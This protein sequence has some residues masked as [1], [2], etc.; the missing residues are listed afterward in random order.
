V[1]ISRNGSVATL[2]AYS[3]FPLG[4]A[5]A[6]VSRAV[7][8]VHG[9]SR[10][11]VDYY[12]YAARAV[13]SSVLVVAPQLQTSSDSPSSTELHWDDS[14]WKRGDQSL[15][16]A[17]QVSS[18][19]VIDDLVRAMRT[20][21]PNLGT[22]VIAGHS[23]GGQFVQ[24]YAATSTDARAH[25]VVANPSSYLYLGPERPV[26]GAFSIPADACSWYNHYRYGL[27]DLGETPYVSRI[28]AATL[29]ARYGQ[30][31]VTYLLG[32]LDTDPNASD[33]DTT[34]EAQAQGATRLERGQRFYEHLAIAYGTGVYGRHTLQVV[35]G[36]GHSASG[37][38]G[39]AAGR[40]AL[41]N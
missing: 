37:M 12:D 35:P 13:P 16:G 6:T 11:A 18:F 31:R 2:P 15:G 32:A 10:N 1:S 34:C 24:R 38:F 3:S 9:S 19:E 30:A 40:T 5:N 8:I 20:T 36:V 39:S 14:G 26:G 23:A 7:V 29:K 28:G 22:V 41:T 17:F 27:E 25:F 33:L 4:V 21:F